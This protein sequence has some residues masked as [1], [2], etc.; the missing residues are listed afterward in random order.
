MAGERAHRSF[1]LPVNSLNDSS[2]RRGRW[3]GQGKVRW[4]L[5]EVS[6]SFLDIASRKRGIESHPQLGRRD[7]PYVIKL[8]APGLTR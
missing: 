8:S 6:E 2:L 4:E 5:V 3:I 1:S 7:D